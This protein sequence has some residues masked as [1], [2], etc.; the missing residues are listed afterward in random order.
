MI[1]V[2]AYAICNGNKR[3]PPSV[4]Q[5][6]GS[7]LFRNLRDTVINILNNIHMPMGLSNTLSLYGVP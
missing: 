5:A 6:D 3:A 2:M 7:V 4:S 1:V